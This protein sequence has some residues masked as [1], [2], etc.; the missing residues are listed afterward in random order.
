[1]SLYSYIVLYFL[2]SNQ[3]KTYIHTWIPNKNN[4]QKK[5]M[6]RLISY[7]ATKKIVNRKFNIN[8]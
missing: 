7:N 5:I 6:C 2:I 3:C 4:L 1:M 8:N